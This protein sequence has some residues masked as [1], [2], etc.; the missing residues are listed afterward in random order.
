MNEDGGKEECGQLCSPWSACDKCAAYWQTM[1][2][3]GLWQ[4]HTGWTEKGW[5]EILRHA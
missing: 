3:E 4:D 5:K 1:R 2:A